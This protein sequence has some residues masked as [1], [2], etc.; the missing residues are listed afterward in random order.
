[1]LSVALT[2]EPYESAAMRRGCV[3]QLLSSAVNK[4]QVGMSPPLED[5]K[6]LPN[7]EQL[8]HSEATMVQ[9]SYELCLG[10]E[11]NIRYRLRRVR[12]KVQSRRSYTV[13]DQLSSKRRDHSAVIGAEAKRW[14]YQ[15]DPGR[16]AASS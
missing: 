15:G 11:N 13:R 9:T 3:S 1:M 8:M 5:K 16:S 7:A 4:I 10:R 2:A 14:H 12:R 6:S